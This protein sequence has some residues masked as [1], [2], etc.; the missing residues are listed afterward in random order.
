MTNNVLG[1]K[2]GKEDILFNNIE[3]S[4]KLNLRN[5]IVMAPMTRSMATDELVPTDAMA[6]Y[7]G[8]RA[9]VGLIITEATVIAP[10]AQGYPNTPGLYSQA[11]V[12][13]WKKVTR[14]V[15]KN[16]GKIFAQIWHTGRV[17]HPIYLK[18][19]KPIAPSAVALHG[20]V[21]RT[22]GLEYG[23]PRE[24]SE[25]EIEQ[26][27]QQF[28]QAAANA[29]EAGFDGVELHGANGYLLDQFLHWETN[30]RTD[31]W[32]GNAENMARILFDVIDAVKQEIDHVGV[33]LS[34]VGYLHIEH[35]D[36]DKAVFDYLLPRL[37][38]YD[39][40]YVHTGMVDD[41]Y[42]T[43]LGATVTQYIRSHYKGTVIAN[44]GYDAAGGR[45]ALLKGE[46]DLI[47]IGRPLIANPDYIEKVRTNQ[48]LTAYKDEMLNALV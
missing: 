4:E 37:N 29:C 40:A 32:G 18:G 45:E 14:K 39:L 25:A 47:A 27:I 16:G 44:G 24:M 6:E 33:R 5:R 30:Q 28:A 36:R 35:D 1:K 42:Q 26:V 17:S 34:P 41:S 2:S 8:R 7:Y 31:V 21:P 3:L 38:Q 13:G 48:G 46:S 11:Q 43:Q 12:E 23:M 22:E 20:R 19:D 10:I 9:D 15:H